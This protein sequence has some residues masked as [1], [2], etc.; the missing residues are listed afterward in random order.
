M[1]GMTEQLGGFRARME[2]LRLRAQQQ[3]AR[4]ALAQQHAEDASGSALSAQ[5]VRGGRSQPEDRCGD[6][7]PSVSVPFAL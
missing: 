7:G 4:A 1:T 2:A 3:R 5:E 6:G